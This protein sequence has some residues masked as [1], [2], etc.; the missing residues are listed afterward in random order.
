MA[1]F[2]FGKFFLLLENWTSQGKWVVVNF[3][4][5]FLSI[6]HA[7]FAFPIL[8]GTFILVMWSLAFKAKWEKG[9]SVR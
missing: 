2:F 1:P 5:V 6:V 3:L 9:E 4:L 8:L 7:R